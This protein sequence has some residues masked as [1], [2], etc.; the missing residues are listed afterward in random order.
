M[1]C[2][3]LFDSVLRRA[4]RLRWA[5]R[6][7]ILRRLRFW[8]ERGAISNSQTP[9][10]EKANPHFLQKCAWRAVTAAPALPE[11]LS[12]IG[13]AVFS[14]PK[15]FGFGKTDKSAAHDRLWEPI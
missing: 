5:S 14:N 4:R 8:G 15:E 13:P 3:K 12:G 9:E 2:K 11:Q 1:I 6:S 10:H 7:W